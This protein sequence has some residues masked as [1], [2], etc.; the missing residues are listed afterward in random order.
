[1]K[2]YSPINWNF[3]P[4]KNMDLTRFTART[5]KV[6]SSECTPELLAAIDSLGLKLQLVEIFY[7]RKY[8]QSTL[9]ADFFPVDNKWTSRCK[10]NWNSTSL[11]DS[12]W[13]N[14]SPDS[15]MSE[16][17]TT[18]IATNFVKIQEDSFTRSCVPIRAKI[19]GWHL[20]EAGFP[21][22]VV[23]GNPSDRWCVCVVCDHDGNSTFSHFETLFDAHQ[24]LLS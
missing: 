23:N 14:F 22:Q 4:L 9:H 16:C 3:D 10:I 17:G 24:M 11:A 2:F 20:F 5:T 12:R 13:Y 15:V 6:E 19:G 8:F 18:D 7:S 1:M 21:H